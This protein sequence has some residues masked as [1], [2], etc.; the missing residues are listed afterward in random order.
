[1]S[2]KETK[3]SIT[4]VKHDRKPDTEALILKAVDI[5]PPDEYIE[6]Y[7]AEGKTDKPIVI[8]PTYNPGLLYTIATQNNTLMQCV[9]AM[10][11]NVDG[12]GHEIALIE[13]MAENEKEKQILKDFFSQPYPDLSMVTLRRKLRV[14]QEF[15]GNAYMEVIENVNGDLVAV[16]RLGAIGTRLIKYDNPVDADKTVVRGGVEVVL[17]MKV[18]ER[19]FVHRV[20]GVTTYYKEYGASRDLD[21]TTGQWASKGTR[22]PADKRASSLIHFKCKDDPKSP[23]GIP[24]WINQLPSVLGSRKAEEMNLDFF[25]TGG[26]PPV[27]VIV[28]GGTLGS[29]VTDQLKQHLAGKG[30]N[31]RAAIV[32]AIS[33]SGTL[34]SAGSVQVKV[35]RFGDSAK[36]DSMFQNYDQTAEDHIRCAFRLPPLFIGKAGDYS[37]ATAYASYLVAEAQVFYPERFE[38]DSILNAKIVKA[39][40]VKN[41]MFNSLPLTMVDV[42]NQLDAVKTV[43]GKYVSGE[44]VVTTLNKLV[45]TSFKYEKQE[46]PA[47]S[48]P[49]ATPG[50]DT[51]AQQGVN[52]AVTKSEVV[53]LASK[54]VSGILDGDVSDDLEEEVRELS[55]ADRSSFDSQVSK[56]LVGTK[57]LSELCGC[58]NHLEG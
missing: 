52:Q 10:E 8:E 56:M 32:E 30:N 16:D 27:L 48:Q 41:Y 2:D 19:R 57:A 40:G 3:S 45:G 51:G 23:Y 31:N 47:P 46:Q 22:L 9:E 49:T 15:T 42:K 21:K 1:M 28:Q 36:K 50:F 6:E 33:T 34:D 17:K 43:D 44:E 7:T 58:A 38:F 18:R 12:T 26:L 14:D 25:D 39:L 55:G 11:V 24:R 20:N 5:T 29:T 4:V 54:W 53:E 13:G 35:E 37:F